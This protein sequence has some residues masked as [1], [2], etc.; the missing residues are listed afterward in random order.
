MEGGR[1]GVPITEFS[2]SVPKPDLDF[3]QNQERKLN[4]VQVSSVEDPSFDRFRDFYN[5]NKDFY[6][7]KIVTPDKTHPEKAIYFKQS[8]NGIVV[9]QNLERHNGTFFFPGFNY[10]PSY[11]VSEDIVVVDKNSGLFFNV[12]SLRSMDGVTGRTEVHYLGN[13]KKNSSFDTNRKEYSLDKGG[14]VTWSD[15]VTFSGDVEKKFGRDAVI[16]S[17]LLSLFHEFGH[18]YQPLRLTAMRD[19]ILRE[20]NQGG[21]SFSDMDAKTQQELI[22]WRQTKKADERN[23]SAFALSLI[24][25]L[26]YLGVD[27]TR[28]LPHGSLNRIVEY[29]LEDYSYSWQKVPGDEFSSKPMKKSN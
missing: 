7:L 28:G 23:A 24:L 9:L 6:G 22:E 26:K 25:K 3:R 19:K 4:E 16:A 21:K 1:D 20:L 12:D 18:R 15:D 11:A 8:R 13:S 27:V 5:Q 29:F 2:I 17:D 14:L 10:E